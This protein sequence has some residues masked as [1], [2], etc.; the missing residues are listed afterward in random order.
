MIWRQPARF[1]P[2]LISRPSDFP[3][4]LSRFRCESEFFPRGRGSWTKREEWRPH[5]NVS[6]LRR[7]A[8][9]QTRGPPIKCKC[10]FMC[11]SVV[12]DVYRCSG[13]SLL[14]LTRI[15]VH[16]HLSNPANRITK[17]SVK[18]LFLKDPV[19]IFPNIRSDSTRIKRI[20]FD[21]RENISFLSFPFLPGI[22]FEKNCFTRATRSILGPVPRDGDLC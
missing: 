22:K 20:I 6:K 19:S 13:I 16:I 3:E 9:S 4:H 12:T 8:I 11:L 10:L 18:Q 21:Q 5:R 14:R 7:P 2:R 17:G 15:Y 1:K